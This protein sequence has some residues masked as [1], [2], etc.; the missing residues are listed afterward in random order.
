MCLLILQSADKEAKANELQHEPDQLKQ[1]HVREVED[2]ENSHAQELKEAQHKHEEEVK[3]L[4]SRMAQLE[5]KLEVLQTQ[6]ANMQKLQATHE[7]SHA[8]TTI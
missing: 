2:I 5:R 1:K 3:E 7:S 6:K 8:F 4:E